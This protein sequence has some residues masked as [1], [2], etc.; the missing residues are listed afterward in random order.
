MYC[1]NT[2]KSIQRCKTYSISFI[3]FYSEVSFSTCQNLRENIMILCLCRV[4]RVFHMSSIP[5][6]QLSEL[7]LVG[8]PAAANRKCHEIFRLWLRR[9][10]N[11]AYYR[12]MRELGAVD[13]ILPL[14]FKFCLF[15]LQF[16][17]AVVR[18]R[19]S[20]LLRFD[21]NCMVFEQHAI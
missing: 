18:F 17:N 20:H 11:S 6:Q 8:G 5:Q 12:I 16:F 15:V 9:Y 14:F 2:K 19:V 21:F 10:T 7:L 13:R 1:Q 4:T 3:Q